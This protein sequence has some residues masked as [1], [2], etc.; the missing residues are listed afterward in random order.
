MIMSI[1]AF[2]MCFTDKDIKKLNANIL[3]KIIASLL[4]GA[5]IGVITALIELLIWLCI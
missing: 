4:F 3:I 5:M 2:I 1:I